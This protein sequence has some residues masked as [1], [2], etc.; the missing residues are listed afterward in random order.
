MQ[1]FIADLHEHASFAARDE[2]QQG[3]AHMIVVSSAVTHVNIDWFVRMFRANHKTFSYS[4]AVAIHP[5]H[6][7]H[8]D[9]H[10]M[11]FVGSSIADNWLDVSP[12]EFASSLFKRFDFIEKLAQLTAQPDL[13]K[14]YG[15]SAKSLWITEFGI[16]TKKLGKANTDL[17]TYPLAIYDRATPVPE[18]IKAIVWEDKWT[19]FLDQVSADFLRH[20]HV[21]TFLLYTLR[22]SAANETNDDNH[23]NFAL[24]RA[25]WSCRLA[26]EVLN[27]LADFFL[28]FRD[29]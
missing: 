24:Y 23:S 9:I 11:Q 18:D 19:A 26:P 4:D 12:R 14:S 20:N 1:I 25:D 13:G 3:H 29:E 28:G 5:Y 2:I 27:R 21:E 16:P 22:E 7:P 8:H 17:R 6:W 10:D 15:L